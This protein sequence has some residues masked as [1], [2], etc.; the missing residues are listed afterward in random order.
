M[1]CLF[2]VSLVLTQTRYIGF[3][4]SNQYLSKW[5]RLCTVHP[6]VVEWKAGSEG[7]KRKPVIC[8][9]LVPYPVT[10]RY[11][12]LCVGVKLSI[13]QPA[14]KHK[15]AVKEAL[16]NL[17]PGK[18]PLQALDSFLWSIWEPKVSEELN[19]KICK[20]K[21]QKVPHWQTRVTCNIKRAIL[22]LTSASPPFKS[23]RDCRSQGLPARF[24]SWDQPISLAWPSYWINSPTPF[25]PTEP[26]SFHLPNSILSQ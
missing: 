10:C 25:T 24:Y 5:K 15:K 16:R 19:K 7:K 17:T 11:S 14:A 8:N 22:D 26:M 1:L 2:F 21:K 9:P 4:L 20:K 12:E 18:I 13:W 3:D 23:C 6:D